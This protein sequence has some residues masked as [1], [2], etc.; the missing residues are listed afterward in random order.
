MYEVRAK[1]ADA[2][3][4]LQNMCWEQTRR[5]QGPDN[6]GLSFLGGEGPSTVQVRKSGIVISQDPRRVGSFASLRTPPLA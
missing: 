2:A 4:H 1:P 6:R 3:G 5:P